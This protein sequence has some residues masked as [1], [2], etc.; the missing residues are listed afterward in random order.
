MHLHFGQ[1][2][3]YSLAE[4]LRL[5]Q[6]FDK[7][8][9]FSDIARRLGQAQ[10]D[11]VLQLSYSYLHN[12]VTDSFSSAL[13]CGALSRECTASQRNPYIQQHHTMF[14]NEARG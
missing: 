11:V 4:L 13:R 2:L 6:P 14:R 9:I 7:S 3:G 5:L 8:P 1:F 12:A 10:K